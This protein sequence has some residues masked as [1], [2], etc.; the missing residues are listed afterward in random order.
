MSFWECT[1]VIYFYFI[2]NSNWGDRCCFYLVKAQ[3]SYICLCSKKN[4][5]WPTTHSRFQYLPCIKTSLNKSS[6]IVWFH[7]KF[8]T[9]SRTFFYYIVQFTLEF[10]Y[11]ALQPF[12]FYERIKGLSLDSMIIAML[13]AYYQQLRFIF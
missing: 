9:K 6:S 7:L 1:S 2:W 11:F 4:Q 13:N 5:Y 3:C 12:V 8:K 10:T